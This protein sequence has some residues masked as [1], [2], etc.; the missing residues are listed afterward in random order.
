MVIIENLIVGIG[1]KIGRW[2]G[3]ELARKVE[4]NSDI[5]RQIPD[6][7]LAQLCREVRE[8]AKLTQAELAEVL[9]V[10]KSA[11]EKWEAGK[12]QPNGQSIAK[13]FVLR[14]EVRSKPSYSTKNK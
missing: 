7:D 10:A 8:E 14:D 11:I 4:Y 13:L 5:M 6:I 1:R 12:H 2:S 3:M 9:G